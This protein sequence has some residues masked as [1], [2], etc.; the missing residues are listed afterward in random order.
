M[1]MKFPISKFGMVLTALYI[2][3]AILIVL[4]DRRSKAGGWITLDGIGAFLITLPVSA[5]GEKLGIRPDYRRNVD[6][7]IAIGICAV[8]V[9][10]IGAGLGKLAQ[11]IFNP[12]A[13]QM[14]NG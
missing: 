11:L 6:M 10:L 7:A 12:A 8:L 3:V 13:P 14:N 1:F 5:V 9:Y 4:G 2:L